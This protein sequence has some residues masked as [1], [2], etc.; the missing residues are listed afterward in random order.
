MDTTRIQRLKELVDRLEQLPPSPDRDRVLAEVRSRAVDLD[1]GVKPRAM[2]P[3]REPLPS[4]PD[5][6]APRPAT[7]AAPTPPPVRRPVAP[8]PTRTLTGRENFFFA[9][10]LLSL[11]DD[12]LPLSQ[13][14]DV[15]PWARG[16]RA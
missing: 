13:L 14:P 16:L 8:P 9:G 7:D 3:A 5:R 4:Q 15:A 1:T 10:E 12:P 6:P 2:L 11:D